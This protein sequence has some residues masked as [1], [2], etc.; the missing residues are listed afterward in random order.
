[1]DN[2]AAEKDAVFELFQDLDRF[3][4]DDYAPLVDT[5]EAMQR[6]VEFVTKAASLEGGVLKQGPEN[7]YWLYD[8]Q[9][10]TRC[11]FVTDRDEANEDD[12]VELMGLDHPIID[13]MM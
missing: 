13:Q 9:R 8:S 5:S 1:M 6:L 3:S 12:F 7:A 10:Q 4:L 11:T 2:A